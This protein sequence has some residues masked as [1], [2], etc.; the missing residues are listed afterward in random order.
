MSIWTDYTA[1]FAVCSCIIVKVGIRHTVSPNLMLILSTYRVVLHPSYLQKVFSCIIF[2]KERYSFMVLSP[3]KS[4]AAGDTPWAELKSD[5]HLSADH[6]QNTDTWCGFTYRLQFRI[7]IGIFY[8]WDRSIFQ[9]QTMC[10]SSIELGLVYKTFIN[11]H[12]WETPNIY[13]FCY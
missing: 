9:Y 1:E 4:R 3:Q 8:S 12:T 5:E 11:K 10:K 6:E 13:I 2:L 7:M